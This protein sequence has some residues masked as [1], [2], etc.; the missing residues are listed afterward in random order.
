[1]FRNMSSQSLDDDAAGLRALAHPVRL[2]LLDLLRSHDALTATEC[3]ELIGSSP[4]S[5]SYHLRYLARH[6]LVQEVPAAR[7]DARERHWRRVETP[8]EAMTAHTWTVSMTPAELRD[9][10]AAVETVTREHVARAKKRRRTGQQPVRLV[11]R[12]FP[13]RSA[14]ARRRPAGDR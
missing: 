12:G 6:G 11:V 13:Q 14:A 8:D 3:A 10:A 4:K 1:M 7:G 9:W 5:C 2:E